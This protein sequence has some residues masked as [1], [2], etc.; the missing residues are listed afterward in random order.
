MSPHIAIIGLKPGLARSLARRQRGVGRL[1]F[2]DG[3]RSSTSLPRSVDWVVVSRF[4]PHRW[5]VAALQY[6]PRGRVV[7]CEGGL[8]ALLRL[9]S[10]IVAAPRAKSLAMAP[11]SP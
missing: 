8:T 5:T 10:A 2:L 1:S 3:S 9:V 6:L 7:Y 4:A 11:A